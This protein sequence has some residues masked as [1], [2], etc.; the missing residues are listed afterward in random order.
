MTMKAALATLFL[1]T[2]TALAAPAPDP[3]A[4]EPGHLVSPA[5]DS[6][7]S[8]TRRQFEQRFET[9]AVALAKGQARPRAD[10]F[11]SFD[12][13]WP[14]DADEYKRMGGN[15]V[16]LLGAVSQDST[17][18]PLAKAYL[19][20]PDGSR[21]MLKRLGYARRTLDGASQAAQVFGSNVSEEFYLVPANA[22]GRDVMLKCDFAKNRLGFVL[23]HSLMPVHALPPQSSAAKPL[24]GAAQTM[25]IREYPGF[26]V[27][28]GDGRR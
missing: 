26:G 7:G 23:T 11:A 17:E 19:E 13:A 20:R 10:R 28:L 24:A 16:I 6:K 2:G 3:K 25:V 9:S 5:G 22:L 1:L 4:T 12:I 8:V 21:V 18:L 27:T 15:T 14:R